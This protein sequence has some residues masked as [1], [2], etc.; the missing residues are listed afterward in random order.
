MKIGIQ[1][2]PDLDKKTKTGIEHYISNLISQLMM[3]RESEK[4]QIFLYSRKTVKW[5][6]KF[7]WTQIGLSLKILRDKPD[8][9]FVPVHTFP[10]IHPKLV[11]AIQGLE[12]EATPKNY[13]FFQ[14]KILRFLTRRN[15]K[16]AEKIIVPSE[17]TKRDLVRFYK[18]DSE[19]I[20]VVP[21]GVDIDQSV[22]VSKPVSS[23]G[24]VRR[25]ALNDTDSENDKRETKPYILYL[26]SGHKRKNIEGLI[27]AFE[28]LKNKYK[29]P[30]KL[31]LI[32]PPRNKKQ[33][34]SNSKNEVIFMGYVNEDKKG[35]LLKNAE[36][37]VFPSFYEGFGIPVLEAQAVGVPVVASNISSLPEILRDSALLVNPYKPKEIAEAIYKIISNP[38]LKESLIKKGYENVKRFSWEKCAR[39]TFEIITKLV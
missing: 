10:V 7:G 13:S 32:G 16:N 37:F 33:L 23:K 29:I 39:E 27:K 18:V 2:S 35:E 17:C 30:H 4:H 31:V 11:I 12:F 38:E 6:F 25:Q 28:I 15:L 34:I 5:P 22:G 8:I 20:K 21:H 36:V 19:R 24:Y 1:I 14:R 3:L 26:G 9:L